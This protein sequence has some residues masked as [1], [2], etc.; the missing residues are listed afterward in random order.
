MVQTVVIHHVRS[1]HAPA[2]L[3]FM[4]R[5]EAAVADAPG[6]VEISSWQD[7][8]TG[9]LVAFARWESEDALRNAMT[10]ILGLSGERDDAWT[11]RPDELL[12][13]VEP[14]DGPA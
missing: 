8:Q 13:L 6:L 10:S 12:T 2:F 9:R 3:A 7:A 5:V 1:E 11:E 4:R 14:P